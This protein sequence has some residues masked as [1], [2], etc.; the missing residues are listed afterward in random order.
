MDLMEFGITN[1]NSSAVYVSFYTTTSGTTTVGTTTPVY[2]PILIPASD[3]HV[4]MRAQIR[5]FPLASFG[6]AITVAA[7]TTATG[8]TSPTSDVLV[9]IQYIV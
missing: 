3:A 7:T 9:E 5:S 1:P 8:N 6:A 2:G 4:R